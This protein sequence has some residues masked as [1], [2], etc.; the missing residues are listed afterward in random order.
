MPLAGSTPLANVMFAVNYC[1]K[2]TNSVMFS[3]V[4][5]VNN[6][7]SSGIWSEDRMTSTTD[8]KLI[9]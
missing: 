4:N 9:V 3:V 6:Y 8:A 5:W 1:K 7:I 2:V